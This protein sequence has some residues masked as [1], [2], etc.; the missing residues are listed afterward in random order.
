MELLIASLTV[1][2]F[3]LGILVGLTIR[4]SSRR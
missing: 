4:F 2:P 3:A 1:I